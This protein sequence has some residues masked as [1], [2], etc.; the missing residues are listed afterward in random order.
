[1]DRTHGTGIAPGD[2]FYEKLNELPEAEVFD[3]FV[4]SRCAKFYALQFGRPKRPD[5]GT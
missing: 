4:E 5:Q 3:E 2:P 1:V